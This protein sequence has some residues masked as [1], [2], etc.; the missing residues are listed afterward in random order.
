MFT[1]PSQGKEETATQT[2]DI[3]IL[4]GE[5]NGKIINVSVKDI[6]DRMLSYSPIVRI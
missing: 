5:D 1:L 4:I 6:K 3:Q 2:K